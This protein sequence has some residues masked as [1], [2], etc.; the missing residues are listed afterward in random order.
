MSTNQK[1]ITVVTIL[2][3]A[4]NSTICDIECRDFA[5]CNNDEPTIDRFSYQHKTCC[6][7]NNVTSSSQMNISDFTTTTS[8][9]R[10]KIT[11]NY[12]RN[13]L[14]LEFMSSSFDEFPAEFLKSFTSLIELFAV[15]VG[16]R[17][18]QSPLFH[19]NNDQKQFEIIN[20]S[21]NKIVKLK[22]DTF[23]DIFVRFLDLSYNEIEII[24]E[25]AFNNNRIGNLNLKGNKIK[26]IQF[27]R[28]INHFKM[29]D[30]SENSILEINAIDS[31]ITDWT[32]QNIEDRR[33]G[34]Q[35]IPS[36][37]IL[38]NNKELKSFNC[39]SSISFSLIELN[40]NPQLNNVILHNCSVHVLE[41]SRD[42]FIENVQLDHR[43]ISFIA[44]N[45]R[46]VNV[47]FSNANAL[48]FLNVSNS[49]LS[50]DA[51]EK[52][53]KLETLQELDLTGN[54][55]G[56]VNISTFAKLKDLTNLNLKNTMI[57][58]ITYWTFSH[59]SMLEY[60]NLA[61]NQLG[62]FDMDMIQAMSLLKQ[63]DVSG[64]NLQEIQ[65][66]KQAHHQFSF[67]NAID[68]THNNF[69]CKYLM[70]FVK[71][72]RIYSIELLKSHKEVHGHNIQGIRCFHEKNDDS[73]VSDNSTEQ[74]IVPDKLNSIIEIISKIEKKI[75]KDENDRQSLA[76]GNSKVLS[77]NEVRDNGFTESLLT[78]MCICFIISLGLQIHQFI[79]R[80]LINNAKT[81][82]SNDKTHHTPAVE[83]FPLI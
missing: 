68:L 17:A 37:L 27:I 69:T 58:N 29:I 32:K 56:A 34:L 51:L 79:K 52:V 35:R 77:L 10:R 65:N 4:V 50:S 66:Y 26:E 53:M 7:Y 39:S 72:L 8:I 57:S 83:E 21:R 47:N 64:N 20:I 54:L 46:L 22:D 80:F 63:L 40:D 36:S 48:K 75:R 13:V 15:N 41:T 33:V 59:Q 43:L 3:F 49:S 73:D 45:T 82:R 76:N 62:E 19:D 5:R 9:R 12:S 28:N 78:I 1:I 42:N 81:N 71:D 14:R 16:I 24:N 25:M 18:L 74:S 70:T 44:G 67:L 31:S 6:T 30:L 38:S 11:Q 60:L 61:D 2:S 55:I 23:K